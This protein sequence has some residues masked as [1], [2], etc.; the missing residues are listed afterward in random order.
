MHAQ[1]ALLSLVVGI[2]CLASSTH[3]S[4]AQTNLLSNPGFEDAGA[5]RA[6]Q[7]KADFSFAPSWGGWYTN[8]PKAYD[9]QNVDPIA[10][11]HTEIVY[12]GQVA[13]EIARSGGTF[14]AA[15]FQIVDNVAAGTILEGTAWVYIEN[16]P[17]SEAQ[18]RI[19][20]GSSVGGNPNSPSIVWSDWLRS[21]NSW[22]QIS[23]RATVPGGSAT[24]FIYYTQA[25]PNSSLGPNR[26][27]IDQAALIPVGMGSL[28]TPTAAPNNSTPRPGQLRLPTIPPGGIVLPTIGALIRPT[29]GASVAFTPIS[30][31]LVRPT[32]GP[33]IGPR[34]T[35][36]LPLTNTPQPPSSTPE[37]PTLT[38]DVSTPE[39][40]TE[41][42]PT[43]E[44]PTNTPQIIATSLPPTPSE[45]GLCVLMYEDSNQNRIQ[46]VSEGLL[47]DGLLVLRQGQTDI[48]SY[49]TNGQSEPFCFRDLSPG[50][51]TTLA[52]APEGYGLTTPPSLVVSFQAGTRFLISFGAA[53]GVVTAQLPTPAPLP[54]STAELNPEIVSGAASTLGLIVLGAAGVVL[55]VGIV[56]ALII[57]RLS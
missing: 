5:Y 32:A 33:I 44:P 26:I 9:W 13:Q 3:L 28:P 43:L 45:P 16:S 36:T 42:A 29:T 2:V 48:S 20:I 53:R 37:L 6:Q 46:D 27:L 34:A 56:L 47:A 24:L 14:T 15:A 7:G 52:Q 55:A 4:Q 17:I 25:Q 40:P 19:G 31:A 41:D 50:T 18:A 54:T 23:V 1:R 35:A 11:P 51:Y 57:R 21:Y 12:E 10:F 22:Q 38:E 30:T 8:T 39:A 49:L